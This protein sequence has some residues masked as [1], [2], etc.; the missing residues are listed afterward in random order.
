MEVIAGAAA[1]GVEIPESFAD[2]MIAA[3]EVMVPYKPSMRLDYD[4]RRP[5][6]IRTMYLNPV[7]EA[8]RHGCPMPRVE[9]LMRILS[10]L[11]DKI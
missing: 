3:T 2:D 5:M 1:C 10:A 7:S 6:E 11:E 8:A 9:A 4:A